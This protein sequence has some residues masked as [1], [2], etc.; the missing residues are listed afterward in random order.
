MAAEIVRGAEPAWWAVL[1]KGLAGVVLG[2]FLLVSPAKTLLVLVTVLGAYWV[3]RGFLGII[4]ALGGRTTHRGFRLFAAIVSLL[5]GGFVLAYPLV[6]TALLPLTYVIVIGVL[7][8]VSGIV[9]IWYGV[10]A[11]GG[12]ATV[13]G[14][15]DLIFGGI[16]LASPYV[17]A[18]AV[19]FVLGAFAVIHGIV[20]IGMSFALR[21]HQHTSLHRMAPA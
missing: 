17:A 10:T 16:V 21:G 20:L 11:G 18:L 4:D 7:A 3:V 9:F 12:S 5:A 14:V 6:S 13:I 2:A 15:L 8:V 19:P 1:L